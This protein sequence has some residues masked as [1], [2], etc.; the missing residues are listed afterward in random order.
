MNILFSVQMLCLAIIAGGG[1]VLGGGLRP[2][3]IKAMGQSKAVHELESLHINVWNA[4]NRFSFIA[5]I[6]FLLAQ[7]GSVITTHQFHF[8]LFSFSV[9]LVLLFL[10]KLA[11]D[12]K[13]GRRAAEN[14]LA[15]GTAE[16]KKD[17]KKVEMISIGILI[18]ST[19]GIFIM[20]GTK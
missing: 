8:L 16:Q 4:Y 19:I 11:I 17:H 18:L 6:I 12:A 9:I 2:Q 15:A 14:S 7:V 20:E 13:L 10:I 3:F 5:A 1:I